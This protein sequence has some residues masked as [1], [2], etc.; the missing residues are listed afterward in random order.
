[1]K[2]QLR[3]K[4]IGVIRY[5][6]PSDR[7]VTRLEIFWGPR[8]KQSRS[9]HMLLTAELTKAVTSAYKPLHMQ[10]QH[11]QNTVGLSSFSTMLNRPV[12]RILAEKVNGPDTRGK[13]PSSP[14]S[15]ACFETRVGHSSPE[16]DVSSC[17]NTE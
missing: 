7:G 17:L 10:Q 16:A 1:M 9:N 4:C 3:F 5:R 11:A 8:C 15:I 6:S 13:V 14:A 12:V 2:H